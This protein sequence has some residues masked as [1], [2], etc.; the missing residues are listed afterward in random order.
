MQR[1]TDSK[2]KT[3]AAGEKEQIQLEVLGSHE[4]DGTLLVGTVNNNIKNHISGATTDDA[5]EFPLTVTYTA[6]GNKY[7]VYEDGKVDV[8]GPSIT[9]YVKVGDYINYDPTREVTDTSK[10]TY[11]SPTGTGMSHGNGYTSTETDGGQ[12]FTAKSGIKWRVL[13]VTDDKIEIIPTTL[14]QK[15]ATDQNSGNFVLKGAIGYLYG[16]QELN[17]V[18]KIYG[19]GK[20]A[21]TTQVTTYTIGG[22]ALEEE[23]IG[24]ITGS[25][26]RS[27]TVEDVNKIAKVGEIKN[28]IN[29]TTS[30]AECDSNYGNTTNPTSNIYYPTTS[31]TNGKATSAEVKNLKYT[32]Y[33]YNKSKIVDT[34]L[35]NMINGKYWL[36][37]RSVLTSSS[38]ATFSLRCIYNGSV[39]KND[40]FSGRTSGT[41]ESTAS[42]SAIRPV[43]TLKSNVIDITNITEDS[44]KDGHAWELK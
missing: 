19:Y 39:S 34:N 12:K 37:S 21:D 11:T 38:N 42:Y 35:Q 20:G 25:G 8:K 16:E 9:E 23:T 4:N 33:Y 6:T 41:S 43:V 31:T 40:L 32:Y 24:T 10:L 3:T 29:I 26:A 30:F 15:D 5:P 36:A 44:G 14:I 17:E 1:A 2:E 13:S 27:I 22:P 18:C 28:E 7:E